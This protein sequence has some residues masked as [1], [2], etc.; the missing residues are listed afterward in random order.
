MA[1]YAGLFVLSLM[2]QRF[3]PATSEAGPIGSTARP[4]ERVTFLLAEMGPGSILTPVRG[5]VE[6]MAERGAAASDPWNLIRIMPAK[7]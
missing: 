1:L 3:V 6:V 5:A 7:G 4:D 2:S